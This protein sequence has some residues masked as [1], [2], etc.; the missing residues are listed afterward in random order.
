MPLSDEELAG[1]E[2]RQLLQFGIDLFNNRR[3]FDSHEAWEAAW[4]PSERPVRAFYQGLIQVAAAFVHLTRNEYPGT[5]KLLHEGLAKLEKYQPDYLGI[6]VDQLYNEARATLLRVIN[7]GPKGLLQ[8]GL[9]SLPRISQQPQPAAA[10]YA[11]NDVTIHWLEWLNHE[12]ARDGAPLPTVALLH[13]P[14]LVARIWQPVAA[15]LAGVY[16]VIA[17]DLPGH[18]LSSTSGAIEADIEALRAWLKTVA[19]AAEAI[20]SAG[21]SSGLG[22]RIAPAI[23]T[24][25]VCLSPREP[26]GP[27]DGDVPEQRRAVWPGRSEMFAGLNTPRWF[28]HWR[29]D[30][31]WTYVEDGTEV[32]TDATDALG[33]VPL[34]DSEGAAVRLRCDDATEQ[35][36]RRLGR[37]LDGMIEIPVSPLVRP[38]EAASRLR[39]ILDD[40]LQ[41]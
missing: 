1:L 13:A 36:F 18:G 30:L 19:P 7:G 26:T 40:V 14:S 16:R 23:G 31:L 24:V 9:D 37:P 2:P 17:P 33:R 35:H 10:L 22:A 4:I 15:R 29:S 38:I 3:F 8:I 41:V 5:E 25:E 11:H 27:M 28:A 21:A 6:E 20:V 32:L 39:K 12:S 34:T